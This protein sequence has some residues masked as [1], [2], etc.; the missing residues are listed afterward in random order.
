M[1]DDL[2]EIGAWDAERDARLRSPDGWL[3]LVGL[4]W[5]TPGEHEIGQHPS[6]AIHL[7]GHEIPPLAGHL[8]VTDD[9]EATI[10]P[11]H[12]AGLIHGGEPIIQELPLGTT[13]TATQPS[14][15]WDRCACT[16]SGAGPTG[17]VWPCGSATARRRPWPPSTGCPAFRWILP[18]G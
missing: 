13:E 10:R 7:T 11:H 8:L 4:H 5:L 14:S 9:L 17:S 3:A 18:G 2:A 1:T 16:S 6:N 12:G 15:S